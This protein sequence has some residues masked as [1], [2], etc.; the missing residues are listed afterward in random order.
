M[1]TLQIYMFK[2]IQIL[3]F[4]EGFIGLKKKKPSITSYPGILLLSCYTLKFTQTFF[5]THKLC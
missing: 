5:A 2:N 3:C 1:Y 4:T